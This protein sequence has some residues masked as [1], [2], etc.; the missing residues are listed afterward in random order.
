[1]INKISGSLFKIPIP[2][3]IFPR[4]PIPVTK[5]VAI[6]YPVDIS[7]PDI[8]YTNFSNTDS[9]MKNIANPVIPWPY[10]PPL[11]PRHIL[12]GECKVTGVLFSVK[13]L[14]SQD[15]MAF[16]LLDKLLNICSVL[17]LLQNT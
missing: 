16:T 2:V 17:V 6:P 8:S 9:R 5:K 12:I 11:P 3:A 4:L 13:I 10:Q 15:Y 1:M 14:C 7:N